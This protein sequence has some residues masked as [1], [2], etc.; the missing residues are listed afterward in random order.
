MTVCEIVNEIERQN[1]VEEVSQILLGILIQRNLDR[2]KKLAD[3]RASLMA[4]H[5]INKAFLK[6]ETIDALSEV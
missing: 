2:G 3:A 4:I 6:N 5:K 1:C